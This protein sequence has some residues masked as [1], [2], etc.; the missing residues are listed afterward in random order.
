MALT[1][2]QFTLHYPR[3]YH[4][5]EAG[6]WPSVQSY[7]LLSTTALADLFEIDGDAR[8]R[9]LSQHRP[10]SVSI[11]H[12][13]YGSAVIR[14][15]KPLRESVLRRCLCGMTPRQWYEMLNSRVF[16][17]V[18]QERVQTLLNARAYRDRDHTVITVETA[19][20]VAK[21][22]DRILLSPINSGS[23][24]YNAQKRG[25]CT[26]R[27]FSNYPFEERRRLRGVKNAVAEAAVDYSI[28]DL[29]D[30]A[31]RVELRRGSNPPR[32]IYSRE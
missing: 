9:I 18:T 5:A 24:I 14:D 29:G 27:P 3:L 15:Q 17:W 7:G 20:F 32:V 21:Y 28:P 4:M 26:F 1:P 13:R 23:T 2:E 12:Q 6:A 11:W 30:F 19:R 25:P 8:D 16:F 22:A 10:E 31:L